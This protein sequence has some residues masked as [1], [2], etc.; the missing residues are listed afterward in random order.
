VYNERDRTNE[1]YPGTL[2]I[3]AP[4]IKSSVLSLSIF[5]IYVRGTLDHIACSARELSFKLGQKI[6]H[7]RQVTKY[8]HYSLLKS[9]RR[10]MV[11]I[12]D[13]STSAF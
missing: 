9:A 10:G 4:E 3:D 1:A 13:I 8:I 12:G 6:Y 7:V 5:K 11:G 2:L